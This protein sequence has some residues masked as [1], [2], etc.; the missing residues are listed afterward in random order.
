M[1]IRAKRLRRQNFTDKPETL[2]SPFPRK[3]SF[4]H[5]RTSNLTQLVALT[6]YP[7]SIWPPSRHPT[8]PPQLNRSTTRLSHISIVHI[9]S[10]DLSS[11]QAGSLVLR[12]EET[13]GF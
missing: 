10:H 7:G 12:N 2:A 13:R 8:R 5:D 11:S 6:G 9:T 1:T 4:A 3:D